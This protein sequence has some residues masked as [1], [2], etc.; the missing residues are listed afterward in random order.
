MKKDNLMS[1]FTASGCEKPFGDKDALF[2]TARA[3]WGIWVK[4]YPPF[5]V[6]SSIPPAPLVCS[7]LPQKPISS[8]PLT[9]SVKA[10]RPSALPTPVRRR[11]SGIPVATPTRPP[12]TFDFDPASIQR[13]MSCR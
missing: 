2:N 8:V 6:M 4:F 12:P 9:P 1:C 13:E 3:L 5:S 10:R 7:R 11:M